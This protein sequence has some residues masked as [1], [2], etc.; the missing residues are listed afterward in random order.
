MTIE[1]KPFDVA[2]VLNGK[3]RISA[4]LEEA[5]ESG[6]PCVIASA[7]GDVLRSGVHHASPDEF[8]AI[9]RGLDDARH[10]RFASETM[11]EAVRA[12]FGGA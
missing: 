12:K 7:I 11:V 4:W 5:V 9:D 2:E 8:A 6:E 10:G 3:E 1:T